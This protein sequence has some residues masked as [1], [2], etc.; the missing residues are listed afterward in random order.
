MESSRV[1]AAFACVASA[2]QTVHGQTN[3]FVCLLAQ[4]SERHGTCHEVLHDALHRLHLADVDRLRL[5]T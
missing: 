2:S 4:C 1:L 3:G 5:D